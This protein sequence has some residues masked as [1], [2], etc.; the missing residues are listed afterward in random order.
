[1]DKERWTEREKWVDL[2]AIF[3]IAIIGLLTAYVCFGV[4]ESQATAEIRKYSVSGGIAGALV[5]WGVLANLYLQ[6]RKSSK[7]L[8]DLKG[9][10]EDLQKKL[11]RGAPCPSEFEIEV[12]E[13]Q[14]IVLARPGGWTRVGGV[15]FDYESVSVEYDSAVTRKEG[16]SDVMPSHF[17]VWY[18][19]IKEKE[20]Y[21]DPDHFYEEF[22][23]A[24]IGAGTPLEFMYLGG[25]PGGVK[26]LKAIWQE[27]ARVEARKNPITKK[28][29]PLYTSV[30]KEE[31]DAWKEKKEKEDYEAFRKEK[32]MAL[33]LLEQSKT[34]TPAA[35]VAAD[36]GSPQ[37]GEGQVDALKEMEVRGWPAYLIVMQLYVICY[38][39]DLRTIFHFIFFDDEKDFI[40]SSAKFNQIIDSVRFLA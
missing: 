27:Y 10:N 14:R 15:I 26:S 36:D 13:K 35:S 22:A 29:E 11:I 2:F 21:D 6:F 4:L 33:P 30:P 32:Q 17:K 8:Q 16:S 25:E 5:S 28:W 18:E 37:A 23:R 38:H 39:K 20:L 12:D 24:Q 7:E 31:F 9:R 3:V 34:I 1:M 19:P 40:V